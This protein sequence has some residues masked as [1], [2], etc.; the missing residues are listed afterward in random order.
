MRKRYPIQQ[1]LGTIPIGEISLNLKSRDSFPAILLGLQHIFLDEVLRESVLS[2]VEEAVC[3]GKRS[4]GRPGMDL[5]ELF[6][7]AVVRLGL[8]LDY[9]SL[10][11]LANNHHR[12]R[13]IM[14][15]AIESG[16][17]DQKEYN[18]QTL[19]DNLGLLNAEVINKIN[20]LVVA[21]GHKLLK[22]KIR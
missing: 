10:E 13:G 9:D 2:I 7:L 22:K 6:V 11:D 5:W 12:F 21:S 15:V 3:G 8:D 17:G 4:T 19:K 16:F 20:V 14:G 1:R 18:H